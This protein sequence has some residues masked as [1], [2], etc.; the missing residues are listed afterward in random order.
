M[1][2]PSLVARRNMIEQKRLHELKD[3]DSTMQE[4]IDDVLRK[5]STNHCK[6]LRHHIELRNGII[7]KK[8]V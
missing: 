7:D 8:K 2:I 6:K 5:S 4:Q 1:P 3:K